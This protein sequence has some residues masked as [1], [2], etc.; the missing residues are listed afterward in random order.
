MYKIFKK[1]ILGQNWHAK[2]EVPI[3]LK[4]RLLL[5]SYSKYYG[6]DSVGEI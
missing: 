4:W 1:K 3:I 2:Q 6:A 5:F